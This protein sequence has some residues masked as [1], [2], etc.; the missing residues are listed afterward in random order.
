MIKQTKR[1]VVIGAGL[2]GLYCG[3]LL[4]QAGYQVTTL[5]ARDRVGGRTLTENDVELGG[6]WVSSLHPRVMAL[7]KAF[8]LPIYRQYEA[9]LFI[10]YFNHRREELNEKHNTL[11]ESDAPDPLTPFIERFYQFSTDTDFFETQKHLDHISFHDW[12]CENVA[13]DLALKTFLFTFRIL[14]CIDPHFSSMFFWIYLLRSCGGYR[15]VAG[16]RD[17]GQEFRIEGGAQRLSTKLAE[18]Q[19]I[20]YNA[21]VVEV[22]KENGLYYVHSKNQGAYS[23]DI[24]ISSVPAQLIPKIRWSPA[25]EKERT[26]FYSSL[27]MG[28]VTKIILQYETS[29]WREDGYNAQIISDTPPIY[30]AYDACTQHYNA[31]VIFIVD[32]SGYSD[33]QVLEQLAFLLNNDLAK[34]PTAIH[35][36]NWAEDTFSGGCYACVPPVNSLAANQ[37]YLT[38]P[39]NDIYFVGTEM[40]NEW[41]GYM[42]GALESAERAFK[43]VTK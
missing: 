37:H 4:R 33:M 28:S 26:S 8:Q 38:M 41:M 35:R 14:T 24:I 43:Q 7:C 1:I 30:L 10:R 21:E 36:K 20:I 25:L 15:A 2:S 11:E 19:N 5:E 23:A 18:N 29:F 27:K 9:G 16:I 34:H 22:A 32:D 6:M 31:I 17:S 13:N 40:A 39:Y 12:C 3:F 42:E